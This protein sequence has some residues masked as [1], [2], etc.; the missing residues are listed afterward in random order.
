VKEFV[1]GVRMVGGAAAT[2][3]AASLTASIGG[4]VVIAK[5]FVDGCRVVG[6]A[7][8]AIL[9]WTWRV[10]TARALVKTDDF[11]CALGHG[12]EAVVV[13]SFRA[14]IIGSLV[15]L[16]EFVDGVRVLR[17]AVVRAVPIAAE[18][19]FWTWRA[20]VVGAI[21]ASTIVVALAKAILDVVGGLAAFA[22]MLL[23]ATA[24]LL[25]ASARGITT[26]ARGSLNVTLALIAKLRGVR[27]PRLEFPQVRVPHVHAPQVRIPQVHVRLPR[28]EMSRSDISTIGTAIAVVAIGLLV[29]VV[30]GFAYR[31]ITQ[32]FHPAVVAERAAP[33]RVAQIR[34]PFE[35]RIYLPF[36]RH[37]AEAPPAKP[38]PVKHHHVRAHAPVHIAQVPHPKAHA[39]HPIHQIDTTDI[40][41]VV[42][43]AAP[44]AHTPTLHAHHAHGVTNIARGLPPTIVERA[45]LEVAS[46][47]SDVKRG[48]TRGALVRLG[49]APD[50]EASNLTEAQVLEHGSY[51][52]V[53]SGQNEGGAKVDVELNARG[54]QF[55]ALFTVSPLGPAVHITSHTL[56][57]VSGPGVVAHP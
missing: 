18:I 29:G 53:N 12:A 45:R 40:P 35:A 49:L 34:T 3:L 36:V 1:D 7:I 5:E 26:I 2:I 47:L 33:H 9:V 17:L 27:P 23:G 43:R 30:W 32:H 48:N 6:R 51:R 54:Q 28:V 44:H 8:A 39:K 25:F 38:K 10:P 31:S 46:Y 14:L 55:F 16:T 24:A 4:V 50:A 41:V 52:I 22:G 21:F 15:I 13:W 42:A 57:P 56:I 11:I 37:V 19:L 20:F